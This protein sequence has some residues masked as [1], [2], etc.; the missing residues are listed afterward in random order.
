MRKHSL[1]AILITILFSS[2]AGNYTQVIYT[3]AM[4]NDLTKDNSYWVY[5]ND[6][7]KVV[8]AFW[9]EH[10]NMAFK[11]YNKLSIPIYID[12]K[13]SSYISQSQKL[14]Y[15]SDKTTRNNIAVSNSWATIF[16]NYGYG[17]SVTSENETIVKEERTT[18]I[19]PQSSIVKSSYSIFPNIYFDIE[20]RKTTEASMYNIDVWV[21]TTKSGK[22]I[23][24]RNFLT[25]ST[26]E[27]FKPECY[28]DNGFYISKVVT[29]SDKNFIKRDEKGYKYCPFEKPSR[30]YITDINAVD[31]WPPKSTTYDDY[32]NK[33]T[34]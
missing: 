9:S 14:P 17:A 1:I 7:I 8:Y 31:I 19:P 24:F 15:Y 32:G 13:K 16:R 30:F 26:N 2:C 4:K 20:D 5:E 11:I 10:G 21:T 12:W 27:D 34:N 18:F 22:K 23:Y 25:Y 3:D 28:I 6:T 33:P 29:V